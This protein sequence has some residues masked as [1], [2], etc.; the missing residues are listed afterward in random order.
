MLEETDANDPFIPNDSLFNPVYDPEKI[1]GF[2]IRG[3]FSQF[4]KDELRRFI[5]ESGGRY[6][7]ELS[8]NTDYLVAGERSDAALQQAIKLGISIL[9]EEQLI[10][11]QLFRLPKTSDGK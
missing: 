10:E 4:S 8:V 9:S 3:D 1:K 2:A 11:S 5:T 6:D 7:E